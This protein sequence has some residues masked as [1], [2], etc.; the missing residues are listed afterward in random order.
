MLLLTE[1]DVAI[2][3]VEDI[4]LFFLGSYSAHMTAKALQMLG[5]VTYSKVGSKS[6]NDIC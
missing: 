6:I 3:S 5:A 2:I 1:L 4:I